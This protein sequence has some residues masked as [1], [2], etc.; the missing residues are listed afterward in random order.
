VANQSPVARTHPSI[1]LPHPRQPLSWPPPTTPATTPA[2]VGTEPSPLLCHLLHGA[3]HVSQGR[4]TSSVSDHSTQILQLLSV[5]QSFQCSAVLTARHRH[6][7]SVDTEVSTLLPLWLP[8][9]SPCSPPCPHLP[10]LLPP[11][12]R[13]SPGPSPLS[14][15]YWCPRY[16]SA[17]QT[18]CTG[19][20]GSGAVC[21]FSLCLP[22]PRL[23]VLRRPSASLPLVPHTSSP[24]LPYPTE[25]LPKF[26]LF[27]LSLHSS[28]PRPASSL[29]PSRS[30]QLLPPAHYYPLPSRSF[31]PQ[32]ASFRHSS[33]LPTGSPILA[34]LALL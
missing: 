6:S 3:W 31:I 1:A 14:L 15:G 25:L 11:A 32:L 9:P 4:A 22:A 29:P 17:P 23:Q 16:A 30:L 18:H 13:L 7:F 2:A 26:S 24:L 12:T 10:T 20:R 34:R 5:R 19:G 21:V 33:G 28:A 8:P 27:P